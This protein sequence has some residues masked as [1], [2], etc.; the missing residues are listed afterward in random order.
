MKRLTQILLFTFF[1]ASASFGQVQYQL[2]W[3]QTDEAY[4]VSIVVEE[5]WEAP[6]NMVS[7]AQITLKVPTGGF[8]IANVQNQISEVNFVANSRHNAPAEAADYDYISFG[9]ENLGT[10]KIPFVAGSTVPLFTFQ[11]VGNCTGTVAIV[12]NND[13]FMPPNSAKAN[14]GN[15]IT[16]LGANGNAYNGVFGED[17]DCN[18]LV[19]T[20]NIGQKAT[21]F[22][23]FPNPVKEDLNI[24]FD[25]PRAKEDLFI[26]IYDINGKLVL[27]NDYIFNNGLNT[28]EI[29]AAKLS[30]GIYS[31]E[32]QG[33]DLQMVIEKFMKL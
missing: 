3:L 27:S 12:R 9:L 31:I 2:E 24:H 7:T 14:I 29:N 25:W 28:I 32:I 6:Y 4:R 5:T 17:I 19:G 22:N 23:V 21:V 13:E 10:D 1:G 8:E 33:N 20:I 11:N 30:A 18:S 26:N 16:V 15:N